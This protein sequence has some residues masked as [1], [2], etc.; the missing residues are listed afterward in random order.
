MLRLAMPWAQGL[1]WHDRVCILQSTLPQLRSHGQW[2]GYDDACP[3]CPIS[4]EMHLPII[5]LHCVTC[6]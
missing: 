3:S 2:R 1:G 5:M 4:S 6:C